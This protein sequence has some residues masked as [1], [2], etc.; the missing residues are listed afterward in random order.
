VVVVNLQ[1]DFVFDV[2]YQDQIKRQDFVRHAV[3]RSI[4][5]KGLKIIFII[6]NIYM[7]YD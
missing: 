2:E 3:S 1:L 5:N 4:H 7:K 6:F